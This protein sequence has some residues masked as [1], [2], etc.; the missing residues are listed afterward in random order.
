MVESAQPSQEPPNNFAASVEI[1]K[2]LLDAAND[3]N[4]VDWLDWKGDWQANP[5]VLPFTAK[6]LGL[7][8]GEV[9]D[10]AFFSAFEL[11]NSRIILSYRRHFRGGRW[12]LVLRVTNPVPDFSMRNLLPK[13]YRL[14]VL[15]GGRSHIGAF[16]AGPLMRSI[17][18]DVYLVALGELPAAMTCIEIPEDLFPNAPIQRSHRS[19]RKAGPRKLQECPSRLWGCIDF[20]RLDGGRCIFAGAESLLPSCHY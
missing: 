2:V 17:G 9:L 4:V 20:E 12:Y 6:L 14:P 1:V 8:V 10:N 18:G 13:L 7:A 11:P 19:R 5:R 16:L 15:R 3:R